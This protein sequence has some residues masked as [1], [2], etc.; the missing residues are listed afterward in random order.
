MSSVA[1]IDHQGGTVI[2]NAARRR[3]GESWPGRPRYR[4]AAQGAPLANGT[5][6][7][8]HCQDRSM[9]AL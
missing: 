9:Q 8:F 2:V 6:Y 3:L 5:G 1:A 7:S 4:T